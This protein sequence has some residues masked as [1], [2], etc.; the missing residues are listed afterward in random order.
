MNE[1]MERR[2]RGPAQTSIPDGAVRFWWIRHGPVP[3]AET[4][5]ISGQADLACD[6]SDEAAIAW[7][8]QRV[9]SDAVFV[10]SPL[11]RAVQTG[12]AV[13]GRDPDVLVD[14]VMEQNFGLWNQKRWAELGD[15]AKALGFWDNPAGKAPPEGESFGD[16]CTRVAGFIA[17]A[18]PRW[19]GQDVVVACH[20]GAIRAALA[21]AMMHSL[22][23]SERARAA[24]P[25]PLSF[26]PSKD[27][28]TSQDGQ[29]DQGDPVGNGQSVPDPI[30]Q[31][32]S[33][34]IDNLSVTV[35]QVGPL[36][37]TIC[38]VNERNRA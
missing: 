5:R 24:S 35:T 11:Q 22:S 16:L 38:S 18:V 15:E 29:H 13:M 33:F 20:G 9:P 37:S 1:V 25:V 2:T 17:D 34:V 28:D 4:G 26:P 36:G 27:Q 7:L 14:A 8:K 21:Q 19:A 32:L 6:L 23:P 10:A 31:V 3:G 30:Q 12:V